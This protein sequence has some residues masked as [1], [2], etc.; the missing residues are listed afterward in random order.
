[1]V[2]VEE[3]LNQQLA[4]IFFN[5]FFQWNQLMKIKQ[6]TCIF[7]AQAGQEWINFDPQVA[8]KLRINWYTQK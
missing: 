1:M 3:K 7:I 4:A 2:I 5:G 6:K 8:V